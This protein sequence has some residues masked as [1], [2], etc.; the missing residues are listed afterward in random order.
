LERGERS[1][2]HTSISP[3]TVEATL[4]SNITAES[5]RYRSVNDSQPGKKILLADTPGHAKLRHQALSTLTLSKTQSLTGVV[6]VVD[7]SAIG[8]DG[9]SSEEL[10]ETATYL[11]DVLLQ[12]QKQNLKLNQ[13]KMKSIPFLIAGNKMDLFTALPEKL[14]KST[15]EKEITKLR[16]TRSRGI[17]SIAEGQSTEGL[18]FGSGNAVNDEEG[19]VLGR[20]A[21]AKFEFESLDEWG[22]DVIV[23]GGSVVEGEK[24]VEK[25]WEWI[26]GLL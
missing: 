7:A 10:T 3:I 25:W 2:T 16:E 17:A 5:S 14:V 12:L 4:P 26:A 18:D 8:S 19:E 11:H 15:L 13:S 22:I 23:T 9:S 24:G 1:Q 21:S 20:D 6:F